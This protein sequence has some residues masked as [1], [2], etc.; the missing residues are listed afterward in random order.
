[1]ISFLTDD[2]LVLERRQP[3]WDMW[4][5]T[6]GYM[7]LQSRGYI[8][9]D[10]MS[11]AFGCVSLRNVLLRLR[12]QPVLA[13]DCGRLLCILPCTRSASETVWN[14]DRC[15]EPSYIR[16][17]R[18]WIYDEHP[19]SRLPLGCWNRPYIPYQSLTF[20]IGARDWLESVVVL[21]LQA[22][23]WGVSNRSTKSDIAA[24]VASKQS[25]HNVDAELCWKPF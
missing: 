13:A 19:L 2:G 22:K 5:A 14:K 17:V 11:S 1:M 20:W 6:D 10:E 8:S 4:T 3:L 18:N 9:K 15:K 24:L 16:C 7:L 21:P 23:R 12:I 25:F